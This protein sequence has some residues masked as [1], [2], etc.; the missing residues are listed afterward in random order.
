VVLDPGS[1]ELRAKKGIRLIFGGYVRS[2][3]T[4]AGEEKNLGRGLSRKGAKRGKISGTS[5]WS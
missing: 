4:Y 3:Q 2:S 5:K 1:W